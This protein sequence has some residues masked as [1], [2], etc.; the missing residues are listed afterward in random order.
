MPP[1]L[2]QVPDIEVRELRGDLRGRPADVAAALLAFPVQHLDE[3]ARPARM[4]AEQDRGG[5]DRPGQGRDHHQIEGDRPEPVP[6]GPGLGVAQLGQ[7]RVEE[8]G[9]AA[10]MPVR[11]VE[12]GLPV[13]DADDAG[14]VLHGSRMRVGEGGVHGT[15]QRKRPPR[16]MTSIL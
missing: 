6:R 7:A 16:W 12:R 5:L 8:A 11:G 2:G 9:I 3:D 15:G 13:A 1:D 14:L 4:V 10:P